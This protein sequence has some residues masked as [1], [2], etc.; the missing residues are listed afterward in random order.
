ML[1]LLHVLFKCIY[2]IVNYPVV[3]RSLSIRTRLEL[4][5][6]R[7]IAMSGSSRRRPVRG[8]AGLS[9]LINRAKRGLELNIP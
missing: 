5:L 7:L 1:S 9:I 6:A 3:R 8:A 4:E 2:I